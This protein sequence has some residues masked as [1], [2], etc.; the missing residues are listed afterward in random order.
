MIKLFVS[1]LDGTLLNRQLQIDEM[2]K[3]AILQAMEQ[4]VH[5]AIASGRMSAEIHGLMSR[6]PA[7][8]Y[9][10]GQN[11][12]TIYSREH[13][14]LQAQQHIPQIAYD[15]IQQGK[16]YEELVIFV[17]TIYDEAYIHERNARTI[18]YEHRM[19]TAAKSA[20]DL[21]QQVQQGSL[22]CSKVTFLGDI[23]LLE[24]LKEQL[25]SRLGNEVEIVVSDVDCMDVTPVGV[26]KGNAV[27][28]L[29]EQLALVPDEVACIGDSY[30]DLSMF[31]VAG[32]SFAMRHSDD[33]IKSEA[34]YVVDNVAEA[35]QFCLKNLID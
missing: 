33:Q 18:Q 31:K 34:K 23:R 2:N 11:G 15:I 26:S 4:N 17:H 21:D 7:G 27:R 13:H 28:L 16:Q 20:A 10:I 1:D 22:A 25:A 12:A 8:S 14:L 24:R 19:I 3:K 5:I 32:H 30:N 9:A 6:Y 29:M 35:I